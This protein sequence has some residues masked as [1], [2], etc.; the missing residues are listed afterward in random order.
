L[1][2]LGIENRVVGMTFGEFGRRIKSNASKGTDHGTVSPLF[3]FGKLVQG[4]VL[5][6]NP[7]ILKVASVN[8]NVP[9]QYDFRSIYATLLEKWFCIPNATV[10]NLFPQN[11]NGTLQDLP[12]VKNG[13]CTNAV[14]NLSS[15]SLITNYPNPFASKTTI[16]FTTEGGRSYTYSNYRY[17][18]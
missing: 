13:A 14:P 1:K 17:H 12:L 4:G 9:M 5:C 8:D 3:V 10:Q 11:L 15:S 16:Q 2:Y 18:W 6:D 7:T